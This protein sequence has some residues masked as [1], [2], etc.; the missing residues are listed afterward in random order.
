MQACL[1]PR[2]RDLYGNGVL[3]R[4]GVGELHT[5]F[6]R[7]YPRDG[8]AVVERGRLHTLGNS[9]ADPVTGIAAGIIYVE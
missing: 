7:E 3:V 2:S 8:A 4:A 9:F 1:D 6:L 5:V